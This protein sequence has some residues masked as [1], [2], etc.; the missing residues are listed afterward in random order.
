[1]VPENFGKRCV[2]NICIVP[3]EEMI[4]RKLSAEELICAKEGML[5]FLHYFQT[6]VINHL[7]FRTVMP[8]E[9]N[10]TLFTAFSLPGGRRDARGKGFTR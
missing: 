4:C 9:G 7:F 1:L 6:V 8:T 2:P 3:A 5:S 10:K